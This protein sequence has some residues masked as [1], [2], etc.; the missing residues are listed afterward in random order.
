MPETAITKSR[1]IHHLAETLEHP[2]DAFDNDDRRDLP[3]TPERLAANAIVTIFSG[4]IRSHHCPFMDMESGRTEFIDEVAEVIR[5]AFDP[6]ARKQAE[7]IAA[8][9][10]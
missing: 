3:M 7:A 6:E 4:Q 10:W 9:H 2:Y 5:H 8:V 1:V